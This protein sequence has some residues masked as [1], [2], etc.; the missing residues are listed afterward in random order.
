MSSITKR[1]D[2]VES[3][4]SPKQAMLLWMDDAHQF[5]SL[6]EYVLSLIDGPDSAYP[7]YRLPDQVEK[8]AKDAM[9]GR[10]RAE[11][12]KF[13]QDHVRDVIFLF[14]LH[15]EA[16]KRILGEERAYDLQALLLST[17]RRWL[18]D[19]RTHH[20]DKWG[21]RRKVNKGLSDHA[22]TDSA[23]RF[24]R[25]LHQWR[26]MCERFLFE[27]LSV[28]H[29]LESLS[30]RYLDGH[31]VL[32]SGVRESV[33]NVVEYVNT[34]AEMFNDDLSYDTKLRRK[35]KINVIPIDDLRRRA[36]E[37]SEAYLKVVV[38]MAK[39]ETLELIGEQDRA[40]D[41]LRDSLTL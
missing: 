3:S 10:P 2:N 1:L 13:I 38:D 15:H 34:L 36:I 6:N 26:D 11:A 21:R 39:A 29:A 5:N 9:K 35:F 18:N 25:H 12:S 16:N 4:L 19:Q 32:Y 14:F 31:D 20:S 40:H 37:N 30:N 28:H 22:L 23:S 7:L 24:G 41:L 27:I 17:E 33:D 8:A